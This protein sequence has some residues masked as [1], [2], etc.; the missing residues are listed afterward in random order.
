MGRSPLVPDDALEDATA[1][2][3]PRTIWCFDLRRDPDPRPLLDE[4]DR[5]AAVHGD[6]PVEPLAEAAC[7]GGNG[8][9]DLAESAR[10][11]WYP[12][13]DRGRCTG[14]LE[15]LNFCLFGVYGIDRQ[16]RLFVENPD[17]CKDGCPAC[18]RVCPRGAIIFPAHP[19]PTIAGDASPEAQSSDGG[20]IQLGGEQP[21][22]EGQEDL[23]HLVDDLD[24][25]E[26]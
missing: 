16:G 19:D 21:P 4:I 25:A 5:I 8:H 10:S 13:I 7:S 1:D 11:R 18:S 3:P 17:A 23:D 12:V 26:L 24:D 9:V 2:K 6:E 14:C 20:L 15:C 22:S